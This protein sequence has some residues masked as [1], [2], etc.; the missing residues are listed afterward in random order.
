MNY[1]I[2]FLR[3]ETNRIICFQAMR[4][5]FM[6]STMVQIVN[7]LNL[8]G[9][10]E[11]LGH[12]FISVYF[13]L[14]MKPVLCLSNFQKNVQIAN[15]GQ[16]IK[17]WKYHTLAFNHPSV[18]L[19][20]VTISER[21]NFQKNVQIAQFHQFAKILKIIKITLVLIIPLWSKIFIRFAPSVTVSK[22][23]IL[24]EKKPSKTSIF[25]NFAKFWKIIK[26]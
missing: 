14:L 9:I 17:I 5:Q 15:V 22:M 11:K 1:I 16:I 6:L 25:A 21:R 26:F 18:S 20:S 24:F 13:A 2:L 4:N 23:T 3:S 10:N 12:C 7:K 19:Y 8:V